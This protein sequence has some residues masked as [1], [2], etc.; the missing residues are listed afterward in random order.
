MAEKRVR[1]NVKQT[2]KGFHYIDVTVEV[3]D[4]KVTADDI[5][6]LEILKIK[7]T[8]LKNDKRKLVVDSIE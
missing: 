6:V 2:A 5:N 1:I 3:T 8:E 4:E 7:E